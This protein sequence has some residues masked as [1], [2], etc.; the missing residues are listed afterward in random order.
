MQIRNLN[1]ESIRII[2]GV[3]EQQREKYDPNNRAEFGVLK[4][5][6]KNIGR[7]I[8]RVKSDNAKYMIG[9]DVAISWNRVVKIKVCIQWMPSFPKCVI[10]LKSL[11]YLN[12]QYNEI[13]SLP[14]TIG[15]LTSLKEL[16]LR[17]NLLRSLPDSIGLLISLKELNLRENLIRSLPNTI[18]QLTALTSLDLEI[19]NL[20]VLPD[21]IGQLTSLEDLN[22]GQN[23]LTTLPKSIGLLTS[24]NTCIS[25]LI[26]H[27]LP[28]YKDQNNKEL[29]LY[30]NKLFCPN[31]IGR[32]KSL[33]TLDVSICQITLIL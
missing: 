28:G 13:K 19:N 32:L 6:E 16:N 33:I 18:G 12:L 4:E 2:A 25:D 9:G 1:T 24:S 22:L 14:A 10:M 15:Q 7:K 20:T 17:H 26:N 30:H 8:K 27:I 29:F 11:T 5:L 31:S 3:I 23:K 21:T